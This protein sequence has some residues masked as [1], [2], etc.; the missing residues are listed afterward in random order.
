MSNLTTF[1]SSDKIAQLGGIVCWESVKT[2]Y[3]GGQ[4]NLDAKRKKQ[5]EFLV[6][7]DIPVNCIKGYGV[8]DDRAKG[9]IVNFGVNADVVKI[10][11]QAY[12]E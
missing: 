10:I 2:K 11:P 5:A 12:Y 7:G 4:D 1:F 9:K 3:W 8:Y 6:K